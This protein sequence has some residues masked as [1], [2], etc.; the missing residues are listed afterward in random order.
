M[1]SQIAYIK[2]SSET[3]H[4]V[5]GDVITLLKQAG[6][7]IGV[8]ES[9][10][11]GGIMTAITSVSGAS[12][13]FRG[14]VVS[15]ATPL[16]ARLLDVDTALI[17]QHGVIHEDVARQMAIG[18]RNVTTI[19]DE[20]TTWGIGTTGVA[21]PS[22]QDGK[23]VGM[24]FIGI[25]SPSEALALGPFHFPG[26]RHH[27]RQ[28]TIMEALAQLREILRARSDKEVAEPA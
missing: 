10:T 12:A 6:E 27:V 23:P 17:A 16:K 2:R 8:A 26:V 25:A 18:A 11:G 19:N 21:G 14:G 13:V 9:L 22:S 4:D 15:Y 1:P 3:L 28:A 5:A 24:V 20:P 7:T